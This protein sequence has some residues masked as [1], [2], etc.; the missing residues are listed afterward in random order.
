ML[1]LNMENILV[2]TQVLANLGQCTRLHQN[3]INLQV[4]AELKQVTQEETGYC[5]ASLQLTLEYDVADSHI[6]SGECFAG[7]CVISCRILP[8]EAREVKGE[9]SDVFLC[10]RSC[11]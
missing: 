7:R 3:N 6:Y 2:P 11:Q 10:S 4:S 1:T 8:F 5:A 9:T